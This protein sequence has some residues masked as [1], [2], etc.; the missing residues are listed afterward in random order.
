MSEIS[1]EFGNGVVAILRPADWDTMKANRFEDRE[2]AE[3][4]N[5]GK[6]N[7]PKKQRQPLNDK[8]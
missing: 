2:I 5:F 4:L 8:E 7:R 3:F 6:E 1:V